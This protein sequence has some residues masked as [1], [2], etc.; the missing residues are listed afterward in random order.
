M[1]VKVDYSL[2]PPEGVAVVEIPPSG[3]LAHSVIAEPK[4]ISPTSS[5]YAAASEALRAVQKELN[6]T[7]TPWKEAIGDQE[8]VKES[9]GKVGYGKGK[10]ARMSAQDQATPDESSEDSE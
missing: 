5:F 7:L 3:H 1:S 4:S 8:K 10:S 6:A 2:L 9:L